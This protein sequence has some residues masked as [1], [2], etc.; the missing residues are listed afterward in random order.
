MSLLDLAE[1]TEA[2][3]TPR[4]CFLGVAAAADTVLRVPLDAV[5]PLLEDAAIPKQVHDLKAAL[6]VLASHDVVLRGAS[7]T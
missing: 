2:S 7:T 1:A 4:G 3:P 6:R 5:R